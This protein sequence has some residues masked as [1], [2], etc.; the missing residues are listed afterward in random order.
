MRYKHLGCTVVPGCTPAPMVWGDNRSCRERTGCTRECIPKK[1]KCPR[2]G[3]MTDTLEHLEDMET[4]EK[5]VVCMDCG[6]ELEE[7]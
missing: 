3:K 7:E 2:C 6:R 1:L 5:I 4:G